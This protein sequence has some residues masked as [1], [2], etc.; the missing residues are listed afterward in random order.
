MDLEISESL[1]GGRLYIDWKTKFLYA[2][3]GTLYSGL[4]GTASILFSVGGMSMGV[5]GGMSVV[6]IFV[7]AVVVAGVSVV[8]GLVGASVLVVPG[9]AFAITSSEG[10]LLSLVVFLSDTTAASVA[11]VAIVFEVV[12]QFG[13]VLVV[14][15]FVFR[16]VVKDSGRGGR[17]PVYEENEDNVRVGLKFCNWFEFVKFAFVFVCKLVLALVFVFMSV[18][19]FELLIGSNTENVL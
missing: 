5:V 18:F 10:S 15:M 1:R 19:A 7:T 13:F 3:M 12:W 16:S 2:G 8:R 17:K 11:L 4:G 9:T 14:A 6:R